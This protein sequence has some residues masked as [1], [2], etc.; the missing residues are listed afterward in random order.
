MKSLE[1]VR[2]TSGLS[3]AAG[4]VVKAFG[5]GIGSQTAGLEYHGSILRLH[6]DSDCRSEPWLW[7]NPE[8]LEDPWA[9]PSNLSGC[10]KSRL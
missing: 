4:F 3:R 8:E 6:A 1:G 7:S 9:V 5:G 2:W 10:A